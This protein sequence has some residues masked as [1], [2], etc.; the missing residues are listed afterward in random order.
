MGEIG[1]SMYDFTYNNSNTIKKKP[2]KF[3]LFVK[4]L[5]PRFLNSVP[6]SVCLN[7]FSSLKKLKKI[8]KKNL[9]ILETGCGASTLALFL[10]C[11]IHE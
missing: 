7:I 4:H 1:F 9:I 5:L 8:K 3:L 2:E 6:D 11:A 10:H